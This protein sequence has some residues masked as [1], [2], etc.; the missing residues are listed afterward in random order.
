MLPPVFTNQLYLSFPFMGISS[1]VSSGCQPSFSHACVIFPYHRPRNK[2][3]V[4]WIVTFQVFRTHSSR[5]PKM[6]SG[7]RRFSVDFSFFANCFLPYINKRRY[8]PLFKMQTLVT[9]INVDPPSIILS[10]PL[11]VFNH[12][13]SPFASLPLILCFSEWRPTWIRHSS[14]CGP[15]TDCHL[16]LPARR[17]R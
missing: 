13:L 11:K 15:S 8:I 16:P 14:L 4:F 5:V 10:I 1:P 7:V 17:T 9:L 2:T 6:F 12:Y 3:Q